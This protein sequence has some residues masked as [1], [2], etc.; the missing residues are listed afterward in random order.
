MTSLPSSRRVVITGMGLI[1]PIGLD[2]PS[3]WAALLAGHSGIRPITLF[4]TDDFRVK[5]AGEAWGFDPLHYLSNK[6]ARRAD[7]N[8]QFALA[9]AQEALRQAGLSTPLPSTLAEVTGTLVGSGAGGIWTYVA[10]QEILNKYGPQRLSPMLIPMIVTDSASV[11]VSIW[12]GACGPNFGVSSACSTG[13][14]A[15][16]TALETIL[17]GDAEIMITGGAEAAVTKLGIGGFDQLTALSRCNDTPASAS[18]PFDAHRDGFVLSEGA[19]VLVLEELQHALARG[20]EP[21]AEVLAYAAT[22]DAAHFT[23][24]DEGGVQASRAITRVLQKARV[25]PTEVD[26]INAHATA[27]PLGDVFE[28]RAVKRAFGDYAHKLPISSTKSSTGHL[29]G[30]AGAAEAIFCAQAL[31]TGWL[32]PTLNYTTPDPQ[33]DLDFVPNTPRQTHPHI[34]LSNSF[35]FGGHN[36]MVLFKKWD[37]SVEMRD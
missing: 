15:L 16:G 18:R 25:L 32:P 21:L 3:A 33:C 35:G 14:D 11:Q 5:I 24:P 10:Q 22:C 9:A 31:R 7:R 30:A 19:G 8:V 26:Y 27:T 23:N 1:S 29:L 34:V 37:G 36:S 20:A 13:A 28:V 12:A 4:P 2:V 6:E 17:R